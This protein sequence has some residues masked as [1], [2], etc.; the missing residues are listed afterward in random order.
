VP[1]RVL[2]P[3]AVDPNAVDPRQSE[4]N[5]FGSELPHLLLPATAGP[6]KSSSVVSL[7]VHGL[8]IVALLSLGGKVPT[9]VKPNRSAPLLLPNHFLDAVTLVQPQRDTGGGGGTQ[10]PTPASL[11]KL[12]PFSSIQLA[13]PE[14][15]T[16]A[17]DPKLEVDPT[18][19]GPPDLK[20]PSPNMNVW[21]DPHGMPGP[22]S[23]GPGTG[24]GIGGGHDGGVGNGGG[25]GTGDGPGGWGAA[26]FHPVRGA[27]APQ[28]IYQVEPEFSDAARQAKYQGMVEITIIVDAEGRV[29]DPRVV[30]PVGMGLDERAVEAVKQWKFKPGT[31]DGHAVPVIAQVQVTFRLL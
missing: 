13:P 8:A 20:L 9:T 29:R 25:P 21:G 10:S 19:L 30:K 1:Q 12:A 14:A 4:P 27:S 3:N 23:N 11:G 22:P 31:K 28:V 24:N 7:M 6:S 2:S 15:V 18:L 26:T 5:P 17:E 16:P